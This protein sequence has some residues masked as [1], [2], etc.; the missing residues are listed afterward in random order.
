MCNDTGC[1]QNEANSTL[2][3]LANIF[4]YFPAITFLELGDKVR[5]FLRVQEMK[6][7]GLI[8]REKCKLRR[9]VEKVVKIIWVKTKRSCTQLYENAGTLIQKNSAEIKDE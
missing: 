4:L 2:K 6:R 1:K 3:I 9:F 7:S 5:H 8:V